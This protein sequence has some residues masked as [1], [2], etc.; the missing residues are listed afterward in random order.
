MFGIF[1]RVEPETEQRSSIPIFNTDALPPMPWFDAGENPPCSTSDHAF[2]VASFMACVRAISETVAGL[3]WGVFDRTKEGNVP[4]L[5]H[6]YT[7][8]LRDRP[9]K[10]QTS[11]EF[12]DTL[13]ANCVVYGNA[14]AQ[15]ITNKGVVQELIPIHPLY[16]T[17]R[18]L[19]SGVIVYDYMGPDG[20]NGRFTESQI[21]HLRWVS[22][23]GWRGLNPLHLLTPI[24]KMVRQIDLSTQ[25]F[26]INDSRPSVLLET[27]QPIPE[28]AMKSLQAQWHK[29]FRGP[30][31][32]GKTCVLP[33][34]IT[35]K[36]FDQ[37]SSR[38]SET[39]AT[40]QW[41][42]T[43]IARAM[44]VPP[45]IIGAETSSSY[46]DEMLRFTQQ[47]VT[48]WV[49]RVESAFQR[50]L[51][52]ED[53]DLN[54]QIDLRGM[55][56]GDTASRTNYYASMFNMAVMSPND[57]RRAEELPPITEDSAD[58]YYI[59]VNNFSPIQFAA[60]NGIKAN[61]EGTEA[62][63]EE[64]TEPQADTQPVEPQDADVTPPPEGGPNGETLQEVSLNGA[65]VSG[66]I[67]ILA[68]ISSG[69]IDKQAGKVLIEAA[70]PSIPSSMVSEIV[71]GTNTAA[72]Q[73][74]S[75][76][77]APPPQE[78]PEEPS[79]ANDTKEE[80]TPKDT[81][82][83]S[84]QRKRVRAANPRPRRKKKS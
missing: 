24:I 52:E 13:V 6:P 79:D 54:N 35:A 39:Q 17:P 49:N 27:S 44:R 55:M 23:N 72:P 10:Y 63:P 60:E 68:Q 16:V 3:P 33:T 67:E 5:N 11:F 74:V 50:G 29:M 76:E 81:R 19:E 1:K 31:N 51:F 37:A 9:N 56:R 46:E 36:P 12:R 7:H 42:V 57:I 38:E 64:T 48:P 41:L 45:S 70:F 73:P 69:L 66:I 75:G 22:D 77:Q 21:I 59:P 25:R 61:G 18:K 62:P 47:T 28:E 20:K 58:E 4:D 32:V 40:R 34:G 2:A 43:E 53:S 30:L 15:K 83:K 84:T 82:K 80:E 8:L 65:Q 14:Y 26:Y 71:D 78:P